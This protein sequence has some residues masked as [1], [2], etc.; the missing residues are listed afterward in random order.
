VE[1]V[2]GK[3]RGIPVAAVAAAAVLACA[4]AVWGNHVAHTG[5][6]AVTVSDGDASTE[7]E[8]AALH[9]KLP[10]DV[11]GDHLR[12]TVPHSTQTAAWGFPATTLRCGV[13]EPAAIT[14]GGPDY[15]PVANRY[16]NVGLDGQGHVNWFLSPVS[17]GW[18]FTTTDR[19]VYI[20]IFVPGPYQSS[21][22]S[23]V[24]LAGPIVSTIPDK[25][26]QFVDDKP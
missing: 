13:A 22:N 10:T 3:G 2:E 14:V 25:A 20:E 7:A 15:T 21:E 8:C 19:A 23:L 17:G 6:V 4:G 9:A 1:V 18:R 11:E 24:D 12:G 26:G 16:D 5:S